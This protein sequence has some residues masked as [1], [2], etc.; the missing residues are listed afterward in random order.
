MLEDREGRLFAWSRARRY[1]EPAEVLGPDA[2]P[3]WYLLGTNVD[4][5]HR[6]QGLGTWLV[7]ERLQWL[8]ERTHQVYYFT[9]EDNAASI[10]LHRGFGFREIRRGLRMPDVVGG[11]PEGFVLFRAS[12]PVAVTPA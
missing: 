4:Q 1:T 6:R 5:T 7:R 8:S 9:S 2:P 11:P 10:G 12:L 3:G